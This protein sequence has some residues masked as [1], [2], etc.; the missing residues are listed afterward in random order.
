MSSTYLK[1]VDHLVYATPD[2][3]RGIEEIEQL[4]GLRA[5][6]GGRHPGRGTCN[7]LLALGPA[8]Y[9]EIMAPDPEQATLERPRAFGIDDLTHSRLA[10]WCAKATELE[11]LRAE[12]VLRGVPL[13]EVLSMTRRRPDGVTLAWRLTDLAVTVAGGIVPFFIDWGDSSHP[14][15]NAPTG[16]TLVDLRAEHPEAQRVQGML[17]AVGIELPVTEGPAARLIATLTGPVGRV[18]LQ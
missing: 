9:L 6:Y 14:A 17:H 10:G 13:G 11:Q 1:R 7:A 18:E 15:S 12:A 3:E 8:S 16:L 4:T 2:L 5:V